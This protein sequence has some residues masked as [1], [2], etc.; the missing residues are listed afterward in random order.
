MIFTWYTKVTLARVAGVEI[1]VVERVLLERGL[2]LNKEW[3][4]V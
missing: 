3:V 2:I 1:D 4:I